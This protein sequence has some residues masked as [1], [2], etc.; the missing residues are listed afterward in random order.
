MMS[1]RSRLQI[2]MKSRA[3]WVKISPSRPTV[4]D[5]RTVPDNTTEG[6]DSTRSGREWGNGVEWASTPK[7]S[8]A[9]VFKFSRAFCVWLRLALS[10]CVSGEK[11]RELLRVV[12]C[13]CV[14]LRVYVPKNV[15]KFLRLTP[16]SFPTFAFN[17]SKKFSTTINSPVSLAPL[18]R[19]ITNR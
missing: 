13:G 11:R 10:G 19:I 9:A 7:R 6:R 17:S 12:A 18:F 1:K 15:P 8:R 14:C 16:H 5:K 4:Y 3:S 2:A